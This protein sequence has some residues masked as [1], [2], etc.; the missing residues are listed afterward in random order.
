MR[1]RVYENAVALSR[2]AA[3]DAA[4]LLRETIAARGGARLIAATGT[5]QIAFLEALCAEPSIAW[6]RVE[7]F[8]LD[9]YLDL[10]PN[11]PASFVRFLRER[12]ID[13]AGIRRVHMLD[14]AA[15]DGRADEVIRR[16][17]A[18]LATAPI[19]LAFTGIGENAHL[20]FNDP[21][22]DL[23]TTTPFLVV[24]L[25]E[26]CR[27]QQV[28]EGWFRDVAEVPRRAI[29]MSVHQIL[30]AREILCL[31]SGARKRQAVADSFGD[32]D[33]RAAVPASALRTH[34]RTTIYLDRAAAAGLAP[35][36]LAR[37]A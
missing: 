10:P 15:G 21:P 36:Q 2:D 32:A 37:W 7:L 20:A 26:A 28:G 6:D 33:V 23:E 13:P 24:E 22:A 18:E 5:S 27:R 1:I 3:A 12:L 30:Q 25:D 14:T 4:R 31:A 11:H 34:G 16:V 17:S 35:E 29:T 19:D 8:H 9:E